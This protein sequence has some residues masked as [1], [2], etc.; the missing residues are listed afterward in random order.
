MKAKR[1]WIHVATGILVLLSVFAGVIT[2]AE[3]VDKSQIQQEYRRRLSE[4][5]GVSVVVSVITEEKSEEESMTSQF[6]E[7]V[8]RLLEDY[9][10]KIIPEEDLE[11]LPGRPR[12][13][14]YLVMYCPAS[15]GIG[16]FK[17]RV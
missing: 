2:F 16:H 12:L 11:N 7:D 15:V 13:G 17:N 10:I 4:S 5:D 3:V 1:C 14:V 6:Q 9:E 8:E